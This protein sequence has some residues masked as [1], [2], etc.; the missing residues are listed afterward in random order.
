MNFLLAISQQQKHVDDRLMYDREFI[1]SPE[2]ILI[3]EASDC[4][5]K[6]LL[7]SFLVWEILNLETIL[8][9]YFDHE[10]VNVGVRYEHTSGDHITHNNQKYLIC[11]PSGLWMPFGQQI[12]IIGNDLNLNFRVVPVVH[13]Y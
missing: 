5:D 7:F 9:V 8:I 4:D 3:A 1:L 2:R 6:V 13:L 10:H 11:E 12:D